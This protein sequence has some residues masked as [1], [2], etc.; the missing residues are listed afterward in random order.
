MARFS[1]PQQR[2]ALRTYRQESR[3]RAEERQA[4]ERERDA[5]R[6]QQPKEPRAAR[7]VWRTITRK[8]RA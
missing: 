7:T 8:W 3:V 6:A 1:G 2:G 5:A 4:A